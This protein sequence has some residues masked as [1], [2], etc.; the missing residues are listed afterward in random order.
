M[1]EQD[2][3]S[4]RTADSE[5]RERYLQLS[6]APEE[7]ITLAR[8]ADDAIH[9]L[10]AEA[11][12]P[13]CGRDAMIFDRK[14]VSHDDL[15]GSYLYPFCEGCAVVFETTYDLDCILVVPGELEYEVPA[16]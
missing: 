11:G 16:P 9:L 3:A 15:G 4:R 7:A 13:V 1:A 8:D 6:A 2:D 10:D 12:I 14:P 5:R